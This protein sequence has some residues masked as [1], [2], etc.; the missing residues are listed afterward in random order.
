MAFLSISSLL[1][2][3]EAAFD[4]LGP[5]GRDIEGGASFFAA[6]WRVGRCSQE[7]KDHEEGGC[8]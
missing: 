4:V 3:G 1:M 5:S 2:V 7:R 6:S 8:R